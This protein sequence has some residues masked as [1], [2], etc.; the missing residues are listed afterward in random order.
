MS[1]LLTL[2]RQLQ[3]MRGKMGKLDLWGEPSPCSQHLRG[4]GCKMWVVDS[5]DLTTIAWP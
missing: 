4:Q 2:L 3:T 5:K 1:H